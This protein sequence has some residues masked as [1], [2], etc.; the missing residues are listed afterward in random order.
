[1][2]NP[3]R[4]D[5]HITPQRPSGRISL[6]ETRTACAGAAASYVMRAIAYQAG[7]YAPGIQESMFHELHTRGHG[8]TIEGVQRWFAVRGHALHELGYSLE[9]QHVA[10]PTR[11]LLAWIEAG[12]GYRGAVLATSHATPEASIPRASTADAVERIVG[13]IVESRGAGRAGELV[14]IDPAASG[15]AL[16]VA[17]RDRAFQALAVHWVGYR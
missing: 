13:V 14:M 2:T 16:D 11:D 15:A 8:E 4:R 9:S 3:M 5:D 6:F 1:M 17:R 12:H 10:T 7:S